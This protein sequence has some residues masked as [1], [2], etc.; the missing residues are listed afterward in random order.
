MVPVFKR[1]QEL[2][3]TIPETLAS[4]SLSRK[5]V[6]YPRPIGVRGQVV[7]KYAVQAVDQG[8]EH[9]PKIREA[10]VINPSGFKKLARQ[11]NVA[12]TLGHSGV[13][14]LVALT[15]GTVHTKNEDPDKRYWT[16]GYW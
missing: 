6:P 14:G 15:A 8:Q 10:P 2:V 5:R 3:H 11:K 12:A 4:R 16:V 1:D 9:V 13:L 7:Q